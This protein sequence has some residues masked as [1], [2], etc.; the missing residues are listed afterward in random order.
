LC[1]RQSATTYTCV[2]RSMYIMIYIGYTQRYRGPLRQR[3]PYNPRGSRQPSLHDRFG[4]HAARSIYSVLCLAECIVRVIRRGVVLPLTL[5]APINNPKEIA[6]KIE[7][8]ASGRAESSR[9]T[10]LRLSLAGT[11]TC[12]AA[13]SSLC[14]APICF[15][16]LDPN[17]VASTRKIAIPPRFRN[18]HRV[19]FQR[20]TINAD[21]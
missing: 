11:A 17:A 12:S 19:R 14:H 1:R 3:P 7:L 13:A 2:S 10:P 9:K 16:P 20:D 5:S 18:R 6:T 4:S 15:C 21:I 8:W